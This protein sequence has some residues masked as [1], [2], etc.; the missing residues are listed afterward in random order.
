[1]IFSLVYLR[2]QPDIVRTKRLVN[3]SNLNNK[4]YAS[5]CIGKYLV[6]IAARA[7]RNRYFI[8]FC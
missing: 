1:M 5:S 4:I 6:Y 2:K 8:L 7:P 3:A